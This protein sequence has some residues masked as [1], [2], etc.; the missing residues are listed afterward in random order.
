VAAINEAFK[1]VYK[2]NILPSFPNWRFLRVTSEVRPNGQVKTGG[3]CKLVAVNGLDYVTL[4]RFVF[5]FYDGCN[6][7]KFIYDIRCLIGSAVRGS[8]LAGFKNNVF[9][10]LEHRYGN[11][12]LYDEAAE[13]DDSENDSSDSGAEAG[14]EAEVEAEAE[15][16]EL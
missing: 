9:M 14:T 13:I 15:V 1:P 5:L 11:L 8:G 16:R 7:I 4:S 6:N 12:P 10:A 2:D 3:K